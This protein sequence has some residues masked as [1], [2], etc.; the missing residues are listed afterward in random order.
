MRGTVISRLRSG[1]MKLFRDQ[2]GN[3]LMLTAAAIIPV[4]GIAGS[5]IDIGRAYMAELR[6]Q[7]ACDAGVLAGR[8]FMGGGEYGDDEKAEAN[9]MFGFNYPTGLY[10]SEDISFASDLVE[11]EVS[12][13]EGTASARLPTQLMRIFGFAEFNLD[14]DCKAKMEIAHT[15]VMLV[16]DV[17]GSMKNSMNELKSASKEFLTTMLDTGGDGLLRI[18]VVPYSATVNVGGLLESGWL[19]QQLTI[20]SRTYESVTSKV[21]DKNGKNCSNVTT[22]TYKYH[23]RT[24]DIGTPAVGATLQLPIDTEGKNKG[25]KWNGCIIE[26]QTV[27][28][29]ENTTAPEDAFD[30]NI[31]MVPDSREAT[32]WQ[33]YMPGAGFTRPSSA[34]VTRSDTTSSGNNYKSFTGNCPAAALKLTEMRK[35]GVEN[36]EGKQK[37]NTTID[38]LVAVGGTYHDVGMAWGARLISPN[39]LF[40]GTNGLVNGRP[41]TRHI[42]YMTDGEMAPSLGTYYSHQGHETIRPR[43]GWTGRNDDAKLAN[44]T[45]RHTNRFLQLCDRARSE[46]ITIWVIGFGAAAAENASTPALDTCASNGT[47]YRAVTGELE[48]TFQLIANQIARLRL[49]Q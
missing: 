22:K 18:G 23:D 41:R 26:R 15:D 2:G 32:K 25:V 13:V 30:M 49:T 48:Q 8:R 9:K 14:V 39:G 11:G 21:C 36:D 44:L 1:A 7:Q 12:V 20:P 43:L 10:G 42:V 3:A 37:F 34:E 38:N 29:D 33:I 4:V 17:T 40:A 45:A 28:F 24:F 35:D 16:L 27:A 31:N 46:G 19:S 5:A 6:L 47:A